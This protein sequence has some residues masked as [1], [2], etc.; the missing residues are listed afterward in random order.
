MSSNYKY[1]SD[2]LAAID[3]S[4]TILSNYPDSISVNTDISLSPGNDSI[5]KFLF[6]I[7]KRTEGYDEMVKIFSAFLYIQLPIL[8]S[9]IKGKMILKLKD[10][11]ACSLN[12][13]ISDDLIREGMFFSLY[14]MDLYNLFD[15]PPLDPEVGGLYYYGLEKPKPRKKEYDASFQPIT[16]DEDKIK[17]PDE[18]NK[19]SD[20][21]AILWYMRNR[22]IDRQVWYSSYHG[23]QLENAN[24]FIPRAKKVKVEKRKNIFG[25]KVVKETFERLKREDGILTL[26]YGEAAGELFDIEGRPMYAQTPRHDWIHVFLG[27]G[28]PVK[29]SANELIISNK[30]K[31]VDITKDIRKYEATKLIPL[32]D[33]YDALLAELEKTKETLTGYQE[34]LKNT[35]EKIPLWETDVNKYTKEIKKLEKKLKDKGKEVKESE[36]ELNDLIESVNKLKTENRELSLGN[37]VVYQ[38]IEANHYYRKTIF[39]WNIDYIMSVSLFEPKQLITLLLDSLFGNMSIDLNISF[40]RRVIREEIRKMV[41]RVVQTN[42]TVVNDCFFSFSNDEYNELLNKA[43]LSRMGILSYNGSVNGLAGQTGK[44][45]LSELNKIDPSAT[46][47]EQMEVFEGIFA[48]VA[49]E[50]VT[51]KETTKTSFDVNINF[52]EQLLTNLATV[53][54]EAVLSPK[55]YLMIAINQKIIGH[56]ST[57]DAKQFMAMF[58]QM[59]VEIIR[60]IRDEIVSFIFNWIMDII[61]QRAEQVGIKL[62]K[63]QMNYYLNLLNSCVRCLLMFKRKDEEWNM[64]RAGAD[65]LSEE[66]TEPKNKNC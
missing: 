16:T 10:F 31:I 14:E 58:K 30:N 54:C 45:I 64:G 2:A 5:F 9:A 48:K 19:S 12:P 1:K 57:L 44:D 42:D 25:K 47:E 22:A 13:I 32:K 40:E 55:I 63:E 23:K 49:N 24:K 61:K 62:V 53:I 34:E 29:E 7:L 38:P 52:M 21:N 4:T 26:E 50:I 56:D 27:N 15:I 65:I 59:I 35:K 60:L 6:D 3:A 46:Q 39:Q 41:E 66:I 28:A 33:E 20:F 43:D 37:G 36:K 8:E 18:L 51:T 11:F 17:Y